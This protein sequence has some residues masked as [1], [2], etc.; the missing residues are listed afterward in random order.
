MI[1]FF[2]GRTCKAERGA[3]IEYKA[4]LSDEFTW[5]KAKA[6]CVEIVPEFTL[7]ILIDDM[8]KAGKLRQVHL[9]DY[10]RLVDDT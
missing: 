1:I 3:A 2:S 10:N 6:K 7:S 4:K 5:E 8:V 9:S